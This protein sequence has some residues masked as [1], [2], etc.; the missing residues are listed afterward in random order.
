MALIS[1][2]KELYTYLRDKDKKHQDEP[3]PAPVDAADSL[4]G[5]LVE[6][7]AMVRPRLAEADVAEADAAPGEERGEAGQRQQP[8]ED[9]GAIGVEVD[10]GEQTKDEDDGDAGEGP[11]RAVDVGE[12]LGGVALLGEGGEGA[13]AAV[14]ARD[15]DGDDGD[16][17]D[18]VHEGVEAAEPGV[19]ADE[20]EGAC[21]DV[22]VGV[23][24]EEVLVV[25][26]DEQADEEEAEDVEEGDAPEDL[27]D[28]AGEG[29]DGVVSLSGGE[30][31]E[32]GAR[33]GEGGGD[34]DGAE[35]AEA[36]AEGAR[37]VPEAGAP[38]LAVVAVAGP[39]AEDEDEGDDDEDDGGG[40]LEHR[41]PELLL[42]VPYG[43]EDVDDD[44]EDEEHGDP[45]G[46]GY[47]GV[48]VLY[49]KAA[50]REFE[51]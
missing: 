40:E 3:Q 15:A 37:V 51:W 12:D 39:A 41:G 28:G 34:E 14:D 47:V 18:D 32:L 26:G 23:G 16:E 36:V 30:A 19:L 33:E 9:G 7:V 48:P 21:V 17:D 29:L 1:A 11:P 50:Y 35:A 24:A 2:I 25:R 22:A 45:D 31:D 42:G 27:L 49:R 10:V 44:D 13:A 43:A 8:V 6:R 20:D 38:V 4:E 46:Y 5:D